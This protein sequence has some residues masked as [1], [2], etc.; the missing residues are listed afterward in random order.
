MPFQGI[1]QPDI[2]QI[3]NQLRLRKYDGNFLQAYTWYQDDVVRKFSEGITDPNKRLD[4]NWVAKKLNSL[5]KSGELYFIEV[6][7]N[8]T[9]VAIGDVTLLENNPPI[10]IGVEKYRGIGIGKKVMSA[11]VK[12][13]KEIEIKKIYNTGCYEDNYASQKMLISAGFRLV[14]H[15]KEKRRMVY[16][17]DL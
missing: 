14:L 3:D 7:E 17:I 6:F 11:L 13:A 9:Y 10:E 5:N 12:R 8:N 1:E 15:D 2:I 4:E 16:E